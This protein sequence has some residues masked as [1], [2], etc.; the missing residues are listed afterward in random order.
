MK[1]HLLIVFFLACL[2]TV[3]TTCLRDELVQLEFV[4]VFTQTPRA[5][6]ND[7]TLYGTLN[8]I[9]NVIIR[10]YGFALSA[11]DSLPGLLNND[12]LFSVS[13]MPLTLTFSRQLQKNALPVLAPFYYIR[14]YAIQELPGRERIA[15][16]AT[17][18]LD[19]SLQVTIAEPIVLCFSG[20]AI[21]A[22]VIINRALDKPL[23]QHGFV[24]TS[25]NRLPELGKSLS[26]ILGEVSAQAAD[27]FSFQDTLRALQKD[28]TYS[29]RAF[30]F[31]SN[32]DT[33]YSDT[34]SIRLSETD[35]DNDGIT[36]YCDPDDDN[37]GVKDEDDL[38][39]LDPHRCGDSDGDSC[40]DC[41][42]GV[43]GFGPLPDALPNNDGAD[44]DGDGL[45]DAGDPD[46][47]N[48]GVPDA[49][50]VQPQDP[51]R[52]RDI[53]DDGCDDCAIGTDGFGPLPDYDPENDGC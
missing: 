28:I 13:G 30:A 49:Q 12:T 18:R 47:D 37:D 27:P 35:S 36:N 43:D 22:A 44:T 25:D 3:L 14:A 15:Y 8:Q 17:Q 6:D 34:A 21:A 23:D 20:Q 48:D 10:E 50:D 31:Y 40:D 51:K 29:I 32:I 7:I 38:N 45:C 4:E 24:Y 42:I 19:F 53:D 39:P 11:T 26:I 46:D 2:A 33:I 9:D 41:S 1:N 52:C 16:S 5:I